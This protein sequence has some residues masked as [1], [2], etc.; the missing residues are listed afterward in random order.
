MG[1]IVTSGKRQLR[2]SVPLSFIH[3]SQIL[4]QNLHDGRR[5]QGVDFMRGADRLDSRLDGLKRESNIMD[6]GY[7]DICD[8]RGGWPCVFRGG[9][10]IF[11]FTFRVSCNFLG[12]FRS[13]RR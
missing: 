12:F 6:H 10:V 7:W 9:M 4:P 13:L 11:E 8:E 3:Q 2:R 5:N 1:S